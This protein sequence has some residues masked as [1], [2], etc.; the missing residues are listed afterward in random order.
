MI[1]VL[2][3]KAIEFCNVVIIER[4]K[5]LAPV[6]A[7]AHEAQLAQSAQLVRDSGLRHLELCGEVTN[8]H[9]ALQQDRNDSQS[10][11]VAE[12]TEQ[13][14]QVSGSVFFEYHNI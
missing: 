12:C 6:L 10:G 5:D 3:P 2:E 11:G 14:S 1:Y 8:V 4:V 13:V 7:T 9:L